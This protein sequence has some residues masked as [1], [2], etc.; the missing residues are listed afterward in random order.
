[1]SFPGYSS[2]GETH[3]EELFFT[4]LNRLVEKNYYKLRRV[5]TIREDNSNFE[6]IIEHSR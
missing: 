3:F 1:M 6:V 2:V 4:V 5:N